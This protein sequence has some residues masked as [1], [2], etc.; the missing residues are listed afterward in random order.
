MR[1][2]SPFQKFCAR[3][4]KK[5]PGVTSILMMIIAVYTA[6]VAI[7]H[8]TQHQ[9]NPVALYIAMAGV[10]FLALTTMAVLIISPIY[11]VGAW[12]L[13]LPEEAIKYA[14]A[15]KKEFPPATENLDEWIK[16]AL[17]EDDG[18]SLQSWAYYFEQ[19]SEK[20]KTEARVREKLDKIKAE[21]EQL[22]LNKPE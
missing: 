2:L 10:A 9:D 1:K 15:V 8:C 21:F 6:Q 12:K 5:L 7:Q 13:R 11:F 16:V 17:E 18:T 22:C 20:K 3:F 14:E 4:S 19:L